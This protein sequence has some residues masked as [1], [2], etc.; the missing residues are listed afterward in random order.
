M[1][2]KRSIRDATGRSCT[3]G[4]V[5]V[6]SPGEFSGCSRLADHRRPGPLPVLTSRRRV[7]VVGDFQ[8]YAALEGGLVGV[9][10]GEGVAGR[11]PGVDGRK[12]LVGDRA[13]EVVGQEVVRALVAVV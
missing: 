8:L 1:P 12:G 7:A 11:D 2:A 5:V 10:A 9:D 3:E 13:D 4:R 6:R